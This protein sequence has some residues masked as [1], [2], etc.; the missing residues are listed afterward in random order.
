MSAEDTITL[1]R[2]DLAMALCT[3]YGRGIGVSLEDIEDYVIT[4]WHRYLPMVEELAENPN[5][6]L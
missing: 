1:T 2:R 6:H 5:E 3:T 4:N